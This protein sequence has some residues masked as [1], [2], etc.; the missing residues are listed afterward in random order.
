MDDKVSKNFEEILN[1]IPEKDKSFFHSLL[2]LERP[3][4]SVLVVGSSGP[5]FT[6]SKVN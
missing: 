5:E 4:A 1:K 2:W 6:S 3:S